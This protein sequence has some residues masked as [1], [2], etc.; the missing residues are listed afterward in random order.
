M[1]HSIYIRWFSPFAGP[2]AVGQMGLSFNILSETVSIH[3]KETENRVLCG[4]RA[5][6]HYNYEER[7]EVWKVVSH[8]QICSN[9]TA[10][11]MKKVAV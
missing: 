9:N 3:R 2:D 7:Y 10:K 8:Q 1:C 6:V 5:T 4:W 11:C